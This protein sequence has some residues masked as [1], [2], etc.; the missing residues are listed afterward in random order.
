MIKSVINLIHS[1][2]PQIQEISLRCLGMILEDVES[3]YLT[4]YSNLVLEAIVSSVTPSHSESTIYEAARALFFSLDS[5]KK[6]FEVENERDQILSTIGIFLTWKDT[7]MR[8]LGYEILTKVYGLYYPLLAKYVKVIFPITMND[9]QQ[10]KDDIIQMAIEFWA[11]I[12]DIEISIKK[13]HAYSETVIVNPYTEGLLQKE[14]GQKYNCR[15]LNLIDTAYEILYKPLVII[16]MNKPSNYNNDD[17]NKFMASANLLKE[18]TQVIGEPMYKLCIELVD[19]YINQQNWQ[20]RD[21]AVQTFGVIISSQKKS[22]T[23]KVLYYLPIFLGMIHNDPSPI[24]RE[25]TSWTIQS[26]S[27]QY[28][29]AIVGRSDILQQFMTSMYMALKDDCA[30]YIR[31]NACTSLTSIFNQAEEYRK[32]AINFIT[33]YFTYFFDAFL[34]VMF[35]SENDGRLFQLRINCLVSFG[36]LINNAAAGLQTT[37][38]SKLEEM[39]NSMKKISRPIPQ[40]EEELQDQQELQADYLS[41]ISS[42]AR[43][44]EVRISQSAQ[45]VFFFIAPLLKS[46][47][48]N[49]QVDVMLCMEAMIIAMGPLFIEYLPKFEN[50]FLE[51]LRNPPNEHLCKQIV[52]LVSDIARGGESLFNDFLPSYINIMLTNIKNGVYPKSV[53]GDVFVAIGDIVM[54]TCEAYIPFLDETMQ[55]I[56]FGLDVKLDNNATE[57]MRNYRENLHLS[58]INCLSCIYQGMRTHDLTTHLIKYTNSIIAFIT[59]TISDANAKSSSFSKRKKEM[60]K[61]HQSGNPPFSIDDLFENLSYDMVLELMDLLGDIIHSVGIQCSDCFRKDDIQMFIHA[62]LVFNRSRFVEND[63]CKQLRSSA[64]RAN[65]HFQALD[66]VNY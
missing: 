46:K 7:K 48:E 42:I 55:L 16:L 22:V 6:N 40:T 1:T 63:E 50:Y 36:A 2:N 51:M 34:K 11:T 23:Q 13:S 12:C 65:Q 66:N 21:G 17:W 39:L 56:L 62:G 4:N 47:E 33:P 20:M 58:I 35:E 14:P 32:K 61:N 9:I 19:N 18:M 49:V 54:A 44:I 52:G 25:T 8:I 28:A 45:K 5:V 26:I 15:S 27:Q 31:K 38:I 37:I 41:I 53:H 59:L 30:L 43:K 60:D 64:R 24:V 57:E 29:S 3:K 10:G